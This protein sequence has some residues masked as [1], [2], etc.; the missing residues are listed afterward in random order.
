MSE[1]I[2]PKEY[3]SGVLKTGEISL[4]CYILDNGMRA[5]TKRGMQ[6]ALGIPASKSGTILENFLL[7][8]KSYDT[9]PQNFAVIESGFKNVTKFRR[10]G[11]GGSQPDSM[12]FEATFLMDVCHFI[13]D[14]KQYCTI[15]PEWDYLHKNATIIERAFSKLGIIAYIDEATGYIKE[16]KK[17]E[18]EQLFNKFLLEEAQKW[19]ETFPKEFFDIIWKIWLQKSPP[20]HNKR[21]Q[22]FGKIIRK[23]VYEPLAIK[24]LGLN[25]DAE[26]V[27]LLKLD[28][29]NP[30]R[31][32]G[33]RKFT[34]H[35][36]LN[37]IGRDVLT[38]H[39]DKVVTIGEISD[40]KRQFDNLFAKAFKIKKP[41]QE[42]EFF[43]N[44]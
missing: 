27:L 39:L 40:N 21:P 8:Y 4:E 28:E 31:E 10:K 33:K 38:K 41:Q 23:Y 18:Y 30:V 19:Q 6:K 5:I 11:A 44:E 13:Q 17:N 35:Q 29:K 32:S 1:K 15:P 7:S 14:L 22:F 43:E 25:P 16:K 26:G 42:F 36:F 24:K 3:L 12:A 20:K 9:K 2:L 37:E 34:F